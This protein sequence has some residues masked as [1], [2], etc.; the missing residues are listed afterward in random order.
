MAIL[1]AKNWSLTTYTGGTWTD[2]VAEQA[3]LATVLLS[4]T[5]TA[6]IIVS[7]RVV[8]NTDTELAVLLPDTIIGPHES[9]TFDIRSIN[10]TTNQKLQVK[11]AALGVHFL[12]SGSA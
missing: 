8:D 5:D 12:A 9:H 6:D 7:V 10:I 3:I 4:N 11:A 2:L 1:T